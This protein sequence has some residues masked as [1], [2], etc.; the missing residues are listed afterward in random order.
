VCSGFA[1]YGKDFCRYYPIKEHE[2]ID[3]INKHFNLTGTR[4]EGNIANFVKRINVSEKGYKIYYH[5][6]LSS[7]IDESVEYGIK[8]RY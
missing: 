3:I 6:G 7:I 4:V 5:D 1:N 2:I 8:V